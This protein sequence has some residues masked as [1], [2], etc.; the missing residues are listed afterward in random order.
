MYK[1]G[2]ENDSNDL[3]ALGDYFS[4]LEKEAKIMSEMEAIDEKELSDADAAYYL[5]VTSRIYQKLMK[6]TF[7]LF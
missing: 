5:E 6:V 4:M 3:S 7:S 2:D 1:L